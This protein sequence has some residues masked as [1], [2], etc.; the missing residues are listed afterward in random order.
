MGMFQ[1]TNCDASLQKADQELKP[2][3]K[4]KG[5]RVM[6]LLLILNSCG[7]GPVI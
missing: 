4:T 6:T 2:Q 1:L 3:L 7:T 5:T